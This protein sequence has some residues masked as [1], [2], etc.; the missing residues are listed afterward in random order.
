MSRRTHK[1]PKSEDFDIS[2]LY[3]ETD[4]L[5]VPR[6]QRDYAWDPD[7]HVKK[8]LDDLS[9]FWD[10]SKG[11]PGRYYLLGQVIVV[12]ND[13]DENEIVDGQQRLTT[14]YLLLV[15]LLN[16]MRA[17]VDMTARKN[18][19]VFALLDTAVVSL[20]DGVRLRSPYQEGTKVFKHLFEHGRTRLDDLGALTQPQ[21][22]LLEVYEVIE[23]WISDNLVSENDVVEYSEL[24]LNKVYFTR[25]SIEDIP[26]ALDYFEKMNRRGLPLA[27]ADL[28][29]NFMFAQV[30][31][32]EFDGLT[33]AWKD[34]AK[35]LDKIHRQTLKSTEGF[36]KSWAI[37]ESGSK[38]NGTEPLLEFWK[39][40][41]DTKTKILDFRSTLKSTA[42]FF[43]KSANGVNFRTE[44][45]PILE[46][47]RYFNGSQHLS[48]MFASRHL[49]EFDYVCEL[50]ER[51]FLLYTFSRERTATFESMIPNWCKALSTL[52]KEA[53]KDEILVASK[54]ASAFIVLNAID[55]T[56]SYV[57]SL[58]YTKVS[59]LKKIR[60]VLA[61][62][63][64]HLDVQARQGDYTENMMRY[65]QTVRRGVAGTDLDHVYGQQF[66]R[67]APAEDK[68][69]FNSIGSLT[70]VFSSDHREQTSLSPREKESMYRMSRYILTKSLAEIGEDEPPRVRQSLEAIQAELPVS[71]DAWTSDFVKVRSTWIARKF[72]ESLGVEEL[73]SPLPA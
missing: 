15:S 72:V 66:F 40:K 43:Q 30:P 5:V 58:S 49:D 46:G 3:K 7:D 33:D 59:H 19:T 37:S 8:L 61:S 36:I 14:V 12:V 39:N 65:L 53:T 26:L 11:D 48:V 24:I 62:V 67:A 10:R 71:L 28:L 57:E 35:E 56:V 63:A 32:D 52:P 55:S 34:M 31:D 18:S 60:F 9:D 38:I 4:P 50:I 20:D 54:R 2:R 41:L 13:D 47:V 29:K 44:A 69:I 68:L 73:T 70:P 25:L 16:T 17:K 23:D 27:A 22:N 64:R 45:S 51:R 21:R 1:P 6:W 42:E